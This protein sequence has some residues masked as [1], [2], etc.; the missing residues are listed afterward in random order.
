MARFYMNVDCTEL[1][2]K[3]EQMA[4][5]VQDTQQILEEAGQFMEG[6]FKSLTP[7]DTGALQASI[8]YKLKGDN[9]VEVGVQ[10]SKCTGRVELYS[11]YNEWGTRKMARVCGLSYRNVCQNRSKSVKAK[12]KNIKLLLLL[13]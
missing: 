8:G 13:N 4:H 5:N 12:L 3:L 9:I 6:E 11:W 2:K 10:L 1:V 7:F